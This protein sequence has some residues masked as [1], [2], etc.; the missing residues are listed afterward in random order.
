[1]KKITAKEISNVKKQMAMEFPNDPAMQ[2]VHVVRKILA[3]E[4][5]LNKMRYIEYVKS[6]GSKVKKSN[7]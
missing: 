6:F 3:K 5:E 4:A 7:I 2:E 1:M